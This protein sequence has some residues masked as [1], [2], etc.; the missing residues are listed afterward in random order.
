[1]ICGLCNWWLAPVGGARGLGLTF[2]WAC[3]EVGANIAALDLL[4]IPHDD[5]A[6]LHNELGV[7]AKFYRW[8]VNFQRSRD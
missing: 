4:D 3:A 6:L 8:V 1:M 7:Q 5:F 2:A